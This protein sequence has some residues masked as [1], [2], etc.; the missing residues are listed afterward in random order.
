LG[1]SARLAAQGVPYRPAGGV[2]MV[3]DS[4]TCGSVIDAYNAQ[5]PDPADPRR[6]SRAYV[7]RAGTTYALAVGQPG[8]AYI[9]FDAE[10]HWLAG[11]VGLHDE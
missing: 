5:V 8:S 11:F 9:F 2:S 6:L 10:Y 3:T 7:L 1:D 4:L